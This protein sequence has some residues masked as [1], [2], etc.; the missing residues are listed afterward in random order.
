MADWNFFKDLAD[1]GGVI[2]IRMRKHDVFQDRAGAE[3]CVQ[4]TD[5]AGTCF[6]MAPIHKHQL[7]AGVIAVA[8]DNGITRLRTRAYRQEFDFAVQRSDFQGSE[9]II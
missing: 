5:N 6:G 1:A 4:M 8:D 7:I 2:S 3:I 9:N